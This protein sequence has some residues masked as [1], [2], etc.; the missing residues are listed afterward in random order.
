MD[1]GYKPHIPNTLP[2]YNQKY[3]GCLGSYISSAVGWGHIW[4]QTSSILLILPWQ[5]WVY[6]PHVS[7]KGAISYQCVWRLQASPIQSINNLFHYKQLHSEPYILTINS[8]SSWENYMHA[9]VMFG[10]TY[11]IYTPLLKFLRAR[12]V[13]SL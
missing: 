6:L 1:I 10:W 2:W 9:I 5:V 4:T 3:T 7:F 8:P 12:F 13:Q 11:E